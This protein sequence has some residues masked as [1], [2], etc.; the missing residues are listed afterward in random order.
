MHMKTYAA[1]CD[2]IFGEEYQVAFPGRAGF[3]AASLQYD[4]AVTVCG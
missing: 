3:A 1:R 2:C 4:V